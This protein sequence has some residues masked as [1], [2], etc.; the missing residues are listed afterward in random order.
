MPFIGDIDLSKVHC[1]D[2]DYDGTKKRVEIFADASSLT[3]RNKIWVQLCRDEDSALE[4]RYGLDP[5]KEDQKD[6]TRRGLAVRI[7]DPATIAA[8]RAFDEAIIKAA[9]ENSEKWF[10]RVLTEEQV[11]CNYKPLLYTPNND[12]EGTYCMKFKI[13]CPGSAVPTRIGQVFAQNK[14]KPCDE[15]RLETMG[16]KVVPIVS[17]HS[18]WFMGAAGRDF[19]V[20]FQAEELLITTLPAARGALSNFILKRPIEMV[21]HSSG[22]EEGTA[23][24]LKIELLGAAGASADASD[25]A[26]G[27]GAP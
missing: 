16:A 14:S 8:C 5:V 3:G 25:S 19:G 12:P 17:A 11:R 1:K 20:S 13:K 2:I 10:K 24:E 7:T 9:T 18:I 6:K 23:K 22:D 4:T 21:D 26:F 15:T 27:A